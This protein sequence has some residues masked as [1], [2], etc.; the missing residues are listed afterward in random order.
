M[1][2]PKRDRHR[3]AVA[4]DVCDGEFAAGADGQILL[5]ALGNFCLGLG[6]VDLGG[7]GG[8]DLGFEFGDRLV[9]PAEREPA[10]AGGNA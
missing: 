10:G 7:H 9:G 2:E 6:C 8:R 4:L 3:P 1:S 5:Q